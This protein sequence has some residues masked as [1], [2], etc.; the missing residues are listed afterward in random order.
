MPVEVW[1][2]YMK[3][4]MTYKE[5][6]YCWSSAKCVRYNEDFSGEDH[7]CYWCGVPPEDMS[8][9]KLVWCLSCCGFF[10]PTCGKCWC[11]VPKADFM[12]LKKLRDKYCC[13][14][15]NFKEGIT[16]CVDLELAKA[17]VPGFKLAL[18]YCRS[19]KGFK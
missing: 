10:C 18:D 15:P 16:D 12:V 5:K 4:G 8:S 14:W 9:P 3:D 19:R 1:E 6:K 7:P 11:N 13:N 2:G 17:V